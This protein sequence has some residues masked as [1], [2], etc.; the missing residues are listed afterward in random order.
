MGPREM[1]QW[2]KWGPQFSFQNPHKNQTLQSTIRTQF[3]RK[4]KKG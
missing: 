4:W 2:I 1:A 3:P